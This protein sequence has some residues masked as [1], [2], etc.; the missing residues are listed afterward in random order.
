[1]KSHYKYRILK[2]CPKYI[3][4]SFVD[5]LSG[6]HF[7]YTLPRRL[8]PD[9]KKRHYSLISLIYNHNVTTD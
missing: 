1:M 3:L 4:P 7:P 5:I 9:P 6:T 8:F 2:L